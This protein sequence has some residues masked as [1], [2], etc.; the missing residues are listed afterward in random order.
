MY[1]IEKNV[2]LVGNGAGRRTKYPLR[3]MEVG[4]SFKIEANRRGCVYD[5]AHK[6][7]PKEF[8]TRVYIEDGKKI[9]RVWRVK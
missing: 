6:L 4:D 3:E 8:A 2:P 1:V 9:C 7:K 5:A